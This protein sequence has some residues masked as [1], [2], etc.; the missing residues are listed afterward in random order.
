MS[1]L[2]LLTPPVTVLLLCREGSGQG[3]VQGGQGGALLLQH[4]S[5]RWLCSEVQY[6]AVQCSMVQCNAMRC[7]AVNCTAEH[8]SAVQCHVVKEIRD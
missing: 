4:L 6:S 3:G 5:K 2:S 8:Y 7:S 1:L